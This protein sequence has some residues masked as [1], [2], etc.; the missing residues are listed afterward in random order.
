MTVVSNNI[1]SLKYYK[2]YR[3]TLGPP[4]VLRIRFRIRIRHRI[5]IFL[6]LLDP[7]PLFRYMDP[8]P[9]FRGMDPDPSVIKQK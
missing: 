5:N 1:N 2:K 3:T 7:D 8:D 9:V 4:A 6:G